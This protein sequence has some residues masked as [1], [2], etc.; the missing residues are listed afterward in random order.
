MHHSRRVL[1][2][3]AAVVVA[4]LGSGISSCLETSGQRRAALRRAAEELIPPQGRIRA[5]G[6]RNCV[7]LASAPSCARAV[8][9]LPEHASAGRARL[10]RAAAERHGWTVTHSDDAQGGWSL[11]LRRAGFTAYVVLWRPK[12]YGLTCTGPQP[13][14]ECFNTLNLERSP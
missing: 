10:V 9:E 8:F 6:Y 5:L 11:F 4:F 7:E 12:V 13:Q 1:V 3:S 2:G 14:D